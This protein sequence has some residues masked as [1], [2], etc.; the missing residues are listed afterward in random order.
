MNTHGHDSAFKTAIYEQLARIGKAVASPT[1]LQL[2]DLLSQAPRTVETLAQEA[3]LSI[4]NA[5]QHLRLLR[6]AR[7]VEAA[8]EGLFVRYRLADP[9]VGGFL[10]SLRA[11]AEARIAEIDTIVR[12]FTND[13]EAL[14]PVQKNALLKKLKRGEVIVLDV[15][16]PEEY[17]AGHIPGAISVPLK[18]LKAHMSKLPR[19][20]EIVAYCRGPYCVLAI[21]AVKILTSK[22]FRAVRLD[23]GVPEWRAHGLPVVTGTDAR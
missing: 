11:L 13:I 12:Q 1:R 16:P 14:E 5:S 19:D 18:E 20:Q 9:M 7:L 22:G 6:V 4:A 15:R 21:E 17:Q 8:K 10:R 2:L 3:G 23:D